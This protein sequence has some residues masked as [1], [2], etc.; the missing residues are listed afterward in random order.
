MRQAVMLLGL[1]VMLGLLA[2]CGASDPMVQT[3]DGI[4]GQMRKGAAE[5]RNISGELNKAV[6]TAKKDGKKIGKKD[7]APA[8]K[9]MKELRDAGNKMADLSVD[10]ERFKGKVSSEKAEAL[11]NKFQNSVLNEFGELEKAYTELKQVADQVRSLTDDQETL[12]DFND[13]LRTATQEF[14]S[15]TRQK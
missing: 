9:A 6:S 2:G 5:M 14:E 12:T 13:E 4:I 1:F 10:A 8:I 15:L 7:L 11:R 3:A